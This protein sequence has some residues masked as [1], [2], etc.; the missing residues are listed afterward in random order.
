MRVLGTAALL[1]ALVLTGACSVTPEESLPKP[2]GI[3][4]RGKLPRVTLPTFDGNGSV[5]LSTLRGPVVVNLWASWC[6]P[7]K[8]ELPYFASV[9]NKY[10]GRLNVLGVNYQELDLDAA[11]TLLRESGVTFPNVA[12][13]DG[14]FRAIGLPKTLLVDATG[15]VVFEEYLEIKSR[16]QLEALIAEHLG[17]QPP[18]KTKGSTP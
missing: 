2:T 8:K 9:A 15:A 11:N 16:A 17:V 5:D 4:E 3:A 18:G 13:K 6:T 10:A 7:C 1:A 14:E 12:D